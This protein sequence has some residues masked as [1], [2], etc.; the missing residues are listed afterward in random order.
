MTGRL[1]HP[2]RYDPASDT[3]VP[4][5]WDEAFAEIAAALKPL[6]PDA[7]VFYISGK[8]CLETSYLYALL[9]RLF[10]TNNLPDS[11]NMCHETTSVGLK[12]VIGSPV[13]TCKLDDFETCDAIFYFGQ[14]P[15]T[16]SPRFLHPLQQAVKRGCKLIV[17]N[18]IREVGLMR[19]INPQNPLQMLSQKPTPLAHQYLQ[20]RPGGDIAAIMG[21]A[22]R[23]IERDAIAWASSRPRIL[24]ED[25]IKQHTYDWDAC[26]AKAEATDCAAIERA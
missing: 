9:A 21:M 22:K 10:G 8:A 16:N 20:V 4:C 23:V 12:K 13:G 6:P 17:F 24:D 11:S 7:V 26:R 5:R 19:F 25:F 18:P 3:Y 14:N 1:T 15:G 2:L